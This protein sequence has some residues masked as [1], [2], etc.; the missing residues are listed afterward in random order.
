MVQLNDGYEGGYLEF[1][2][3]DRKG[4]WFKVPKDDERKYNYFPMFLIT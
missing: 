3:Q 2:V 4:E 1:G